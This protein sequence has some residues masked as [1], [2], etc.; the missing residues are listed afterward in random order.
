MGQAST[1]A[2]I[3]GKKERELLS[4]HVAAHERVQFCLVGNSNQAMVVLTDRVLIL[5]TGFMAGTMFGGRA[6]A[7]QFTDIGGVQVN[8]GLINGSIEI[9]TPGMGAT[10]AGDYFTMDPK[11]DPFKLPNCIPIAKSDLTTFQP[12][13]ERLRGMIAAARASR[14]SATLASETGR[15]IASQ[16]Q[17]LGE[18]H[19]A[20]VLS[21][22]EFAAAKKRALERA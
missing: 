20:G 1:D 10:K 9:H 21:D 13:L 22:E 16:L 19:R 12:Y 3:L 17:K 6:T 14:G 4:Q 5:K 2:S 11:S 18:L 15:D 8:T 7:F